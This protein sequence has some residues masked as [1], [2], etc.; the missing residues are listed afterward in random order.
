MQRALLVLVSKRQSPGDYAAHAPRSKA[1]APDS[2]I[3]ADRRTEL[4][5]VLQH[6][7]DRLAR[8]LDFLRRESRRGLLFSPSLEDPHMHD[9]LVG[10]AVDGKPIFVLGRLSRVDDREG[11]HPELR[12]GCDARVRVTPLG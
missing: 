10:M 2:C 9:E 7:R 12:L 4:S 5:Q 3:T 6:P 8:A 1:Q 11:M